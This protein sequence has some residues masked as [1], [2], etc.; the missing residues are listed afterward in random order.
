M[1]GFDQIGAF[2]VP[3]KNGQPFYD[4]IMYF[5]SL[6]VDK[7]PEYYFIKNGKYLNWH[8]YE[9]GGAIQSSKAPDY[10][11][12]RDGS[13][14]TIVLD[15]N[16]PYFPHPASRLHNSLAAKPCKTIIDET[17]QTLVSKRLVGF[18]KFM[19]TRFNSIE[20][21]LKKKEDAAKF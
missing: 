4:A 1:T 5:P 3:I 8:D 20:K 15:W 10:I 18:S 21:E 11:L 14:L 12:S 2:V 7:K 6:Y 16:Q 13:G 9:I 17:P 19:E